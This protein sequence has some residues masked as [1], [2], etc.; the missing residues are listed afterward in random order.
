MPDN[1]NRDIKTEGKFAFKFNDRV[2]D[3]VTSFSGVVI[4]CAFYPD[5]QNSYW[6]AGIDSTGRPIELWVTESR[7]RHHYQ[8]KVD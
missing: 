2:T 4:G 3:K 5:D 6:I 7:L 8:K 1:D